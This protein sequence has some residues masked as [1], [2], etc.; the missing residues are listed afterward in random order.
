[1]TK[2]ILY[3]ILG[4]ILAFGLLFLLW[5]W[6]FSGGNTAQTNGQFGTA[7]NATGNA[8]LNANSNNGQTNLGQNT[9]NGSIPL[10]GS[11]TNANSGGINGNSSSSGGSATSAFATYSPSV[12]GVQWLNSA[13]NNFNPTD[14]NSV[15]GASVGGTVPTLS[16]LKG[17]GSGGN[18]QLNLL[19][20]AGLIGVGSCALQASGQTIGSLI[21]G[22]TAALA[23]SVAGTALAVPTDDIET[24]TLQGAQLANTAGHNVVTFQGC[25]T[26]VLAK[27]ALQQ[28]TASVVNWINSGFKGQPSFVTN[29][30]QFFDNV[31][32]LAAGQFIQ[33]A[34]LSFL[35]SPFKAQIK[36]AVAQSYANRGAQSCTLTSV[37]NNINSFMNGNFSQGGWPGLISY[38]TTPTNNPYGAYA[39]AQI[40]LVT[41]QNN[42]VANA[43]SNISP[44]GFLNMVQQSCSGVTSVSSSVT[45]GQ[46]SQAAQVSCPSGCTCKTTTPGSV[47][48]ASLNKTLGSG[49]DQL[50]LASDL[51]Q[52]IN[53]LTTQ[54]LTQAL[55]GGLSNLSGTDGVQS[56]YQTPEEQA[57]QTQ[58][59][60]ILTNL[61]AQVGYAQQYGSIEQGSISD[62]ENAQSA[63]NSLINCWDGIASSTSFSSSQQSTAA[64]NAANAQATSNTFDAQITSYNNAI[65]A[66]NAEIATIEELQTE[67]LSIASTADVDQLTTDY[68]N[69]QS[70]TP[71]ISATDVT[72]AQ[73]NRT[74][75]QSQLASLNTS[76][77]ESLTQCQAFGH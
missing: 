50:G 69:A 29:Y 55:Q 72:T 71:F 58:A 30:Q 1:M 2:K 51:D 12:A 77:Q 31:A 46:N 11:N 8:S 27:I 75:L 52:I 18:S 3:I 59:Q 22:G 35:C 44:T 40:G 7:G 36:I 39:Y 6:L 28:I 15:N 37:I 57:A 9:A 56:S 16:S 33:G 25:L 38:T 64:S 48:E 45:A 14:I 43:K 62:I 5:S 19:L 53:A 21:G 49:V 17:S 20:A 23:P 10:N 66:V 74:T 41:A 13:D 68:N 34:G 32:N 67:A 61:Q 24:H 54:L 70:T 65:T 73:Q 63:L 76:T 4:A 42:A 47:I 60:G 26:N